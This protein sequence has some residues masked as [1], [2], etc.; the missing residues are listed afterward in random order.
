MGNYPFLMSGDIM[1]L[2]KNFSRAEMLVSNT[3]TRKGISNEPDSPGIEENILKSAKFLQLV[4][5][6]LGKPIRVLSCYRSPAVNKA[7]G[8]SKTSAHMKGLAVDIQVDG[9]SNKALAEFIRDNFEYDQII[10]EFPPN[11]WVHVG[12]K[13]FTAKRMQLLTASKVNGK[14]VYTTGLA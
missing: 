2:T 6:K 3:A 8:G 13:T 1:Q 10:L 7:V 4:R 11:G 5:D 12:I 14:T 9:M